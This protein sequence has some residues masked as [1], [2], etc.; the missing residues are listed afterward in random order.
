[1]GFSLDLQQP[2]LGGQH[3]PTRASGDHTG[4]AFREDGIAR[5]LLGGFAVER[6]GPGVLAPDL[7]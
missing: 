6:L 7:G 2:A 1:M 5:Q 3:R 4:V